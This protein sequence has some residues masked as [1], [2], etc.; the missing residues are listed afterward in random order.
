MEYAHLISRDFPETATWLTWWLCLAHAS[1]LFESQ[2]AAGRNHDFF[3][4]LNGLYA[5]AV[6][7]GNPYNTYDRKLLITSESLVMLLN[8]HEQQVCQKK[9]VKNDGSKGRAFKKGSPRIG[10]KNSRYLRVI[11]FVVM[12]GKTTPVG[13]VHPS[14]SRLQIKKPLNERLL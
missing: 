11:E 7:Y 12:F 8:R 4:G 13:W 2:N 9:W 10:C 3:N 6:Y 14:R 1:M 5:V